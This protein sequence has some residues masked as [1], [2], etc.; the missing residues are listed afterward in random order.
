[1]ATK[2]RSERLIVPEPS[3]DMHRRMNFQKTFSGFSET[4]GR[5]AIIRPNLCNQNPLH[6]MSALDFLT[7]GFLTLRVLV[8]PS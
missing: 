7:T 5:R 1:M 4:E 6:I 2:L 8:Q 3:L